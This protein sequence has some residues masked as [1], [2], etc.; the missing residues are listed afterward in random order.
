MIG[1]H[2]TREFS[3]Y[4][5]TFAGVSDLINFAHLKEPKN[6]VYVGLKFMPIKMYDD[7]YLVDIDLQHLFVF[8]KSADELAVKMKSVN[9]VSGV[10]PQWVARNI[11]PV[12]YWN[13]KS[14]IMQISDCDDVDIPKLANHPVKKV[15]LATKIA[16][17]LVKSF[18]ADPA[19]EDFTTP[20]AQP[21]DYLKE[22][23]P[24]VKKSFTSK[25]AQFVK[26]LISEDED[27]E[28]V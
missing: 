22:K 24:K 1:I 2:K 11:S 6:G 15:S 13:W 12:A 7:K 14:Y 5:V 8:A 4:G 16:N 26:D 19:D 18:E 3:V 9:M 23:T 27:P 28:F 25:M 20:K 10:H 21:R 17:A